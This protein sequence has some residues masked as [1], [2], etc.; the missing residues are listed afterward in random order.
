MVQMKSTLKFY[1]VAMTP[2]LLSLNAAGAE[3]TPEDPAEARLVVHVMNR[4]SGGLSVANDTVRVKV[5]AGEELLGYWDA[6]ANES[7]QAVFAGLPA[8]SDNIAV[9][10]CEHQGI[11]FQVHH[12]IRLLPGRDHAAGIDVYDTSD[13]TAQLAVTVHHMIIKRAGEALAI[14]EYMRLANSSDRVIRPDRLDEQGRP[15][16]LSILLPE[17]FRD[18]KSASYFATEALV[19]TNEGFYDTMAVAPGEYDI[20]FSYELDISDET[21]DFSKEFSLPTAQSILF[22]VLPQARPEGLTVSASQFTMADGA[23]ADYY[24]LGPYKP[25]DVL[26]LRLVGFTIQKEDRSIWIILPVVFVLVAAA[27]LRRLGLGSS[28]QGNSRKSRT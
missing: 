8:G 2:L 21:L 10:M 5:F 16:V 1:L 27:A 15:I 6:T 24:E 20:K 14:T 23:V 3:K 4:T 28:K 17:G 22:L 13:D 11:Q 12:P 26:Q 7:G 9:A 25:G 19:M 18:L